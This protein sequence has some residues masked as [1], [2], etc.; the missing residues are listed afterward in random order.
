MADGGLW[1]IV[2]TDTGRQNIEEKHRRDGPY[3]A[4]KGVFRDDLTIEEIVS[5]AEHIAPS[6]QPSTGR[7]VRIASVDTVEP[8]GGDRDDDPRWEYTVVTE[9]NSAAEPQELFNAFP[10]R[11][12]E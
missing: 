5:G 10:G 1:P 8:V 6:Y 3:S 2:I 7:W 11:P 9:A 12:N 4:G